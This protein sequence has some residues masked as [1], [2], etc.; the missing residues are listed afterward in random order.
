MEMVSVEGNTP[1][2]EYSVAWSNGRLVMGDATSDPMKVMAKM[3]S[4]FPI[5]LRVDPQTRTVRFFAMD[6]YS[7]FKFIRRLQQALADLVRV[8]VID[9]DWRIRIGLSEESTRQNLGST[10]VGAAIDFNAHYSSVIPRAFHG[11]NTHVLPE[12]KSSGLRP[13]SK[14]GGAKNW[15]RFYTD[16]SDYQVYLT[17]DI[18]RAQYYAIKATEVARKAG[19]EC[20][21]VV[22]RFENVPIKSAVADD[23]FASNMGMMQLMDMIRTGQG[24]QDRA[25]KSPL[26]KSIRASSQFAVKSTIPPS[27]I[28]EVIPSS[29]LSL[30]D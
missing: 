23:D 26:V 17:T 20:D 21:P 14:T 13:R 29:K 2:D 6:D 30:F 4:S 16:K 15:E 10:T 8:K 5:Y 19:I 3:G 11:T 7:E 28:A 12:I 1:T 27:M 18:D 24:V 9:K 22:I 25:N